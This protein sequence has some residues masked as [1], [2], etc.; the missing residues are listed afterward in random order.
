MSTFSYFYGHH[1]STIEGEMIS[2]SDDE[3]NELLILKEHMVGYEIFHHHLKG[4]I[5]IN[6][7]F[8]I[9]NHY[10]HSIQL[11]I[12]TFNRCFCLL[13]IESNENIDEY[14]KIRNKNYEYYKKSLNHFWKQD[15]SD[16]FISNFSY[17]MLFN[18]R[19]TIAKDLMRMVLNA[20]H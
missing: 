16:S 13:R 3:M 8:L 18:D 17:G 1:I 6:S 15:C 9:L 20:D 5:Q 7:I 14:E 12:C 10:I 2:T 11:D 4:N 19:D